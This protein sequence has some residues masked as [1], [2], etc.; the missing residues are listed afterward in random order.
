MIKKLLKFLFSRVVIV[1]AMLMFQLA[2]V[3]IVALRFSEFYFTFYLVSLIMSGIVTVHI[4]N[5]KDN[6]S[7]KIAWIVPVLAIPIL[8]VTT[9]YIF[10]GNRLTNHKKK[11]MQNITE[12]MKHVLD[13]KDNDTVRKFASEHPEAANQVKYINDYAYS[14]PYQNTYTKYYSSGEDMF[15]ALISELEKAEKY[16]FLEYFII[17][18]GYMWKEILSIL[19]RKASCGVDVRIIY[20]DMGTIMLLPAK[21]ANTLRK[22][23]I[24]CQVFNRFIPVLSSR[25]NNRNHR[26]IGVIDGHTAFT[27]GVNLADEYIN[28]IERFGYWKD[29]AVMV[30]GDAAWSFAVMFLTMWDYV[31]YK[32]TSVTSTDE[33]MRFKPER[34]IFT[35][36]EKAHL[37]G[38]VQPYTDNPLDN[39]PVGETIYLNIIN[40]AEKYVYISTPYLI[41]DNEMV[42]ALCNAAKGGIDVRITTPYIGDKLIIHETTKSFYEHLI[43]NGVRI[44]EYTPGF[45]HSKTFV[46]DGTV[47]TVGSVNL[48][49]RSL[50]LHFECGVWMHG[51]DSVADIYGDYVE[52]LKSC[53]EITAEMCAKV[54]I[55]RRIFRS[56][57]VTFAPLM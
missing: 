8:G 29:S 41:I 43:N 31:D 33:Y 34:I 18:E 53:N 46:C 5:K 44:Y 4:I 54:N 10:S 37:R 30:K 32:D 48:D 42:T 11:K 14:P 49:Y 55:F 19:E 26:K 28:K 16:I 13:T 36:E 35:D 38:Y 39:E 22:K 23:G 17:Q 25:L 27:G 21:F 7:Y 15:N 45:I 40:K 6:P 51:T 52:M 20:D 56:V 3:F 24:K 57:M 2:L 50:Y 47:G 9:Y 1:A 12:T